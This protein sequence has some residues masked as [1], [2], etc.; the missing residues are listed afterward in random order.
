MRERWQERKKERER[1]RNEKRK[2]KEKERKREKNEKKKRKDS[3]F[4]HV[5]NTIKR[6]I[7]LIYKKK[8]KSKMRKNSNVFHLLSQT[9]RGIGHEESTFHILIHSRSPHR[10]LCKNNK[11]EEKRV[12]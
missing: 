5:K 10:G 12:S 6:K 7:L 4:L 3:F 2:R 1:E 11:D 9:Y 8:F